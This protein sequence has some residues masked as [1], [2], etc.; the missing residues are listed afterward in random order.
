MKVAL[1]A[2]HFGVK[3]STVYRWLKSGDLNQRKG[4]TPKVILLDEK[5]QKLCAKKNR[6][7]QQE[8]EIIQQT[9]EAETAEI[10]IDA[11]A[12]E[13]IENLQKENAELGE[14]VDELRQSNEKLQKEYD[15]TESAYLFL[16]GCENLGKTEEG[17]IATLAKENEALS[18]AKANLDYENE[19]L[20][21]T[22]DDLQREKDQLGSFV[23]CLINDNKRMKLENAELR[24]K[25]AQQQEYIEE[26]NLD[27]LRAQISEL[28]DRC[29]R[30]EKR[31]RS[32][33]KLLF[34]KNEE[35][36]QLRNP[37]TTVHAI[38]EAH[39]NDVVLATEVIDEF[40]AACMRAGYSPNSQ[41]AQICKE[42][43]LEI[44]S[45][46]MAQQIEISLICAPKN[47]GGFEVYSSNGATA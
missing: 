36:E 3:L 42:R 41:F 44:D 18:K 7:Y 32:S 10:K 1:V 45:L 35:I 27:E 16:A 37:A 11:K 5:F 40:E 38:V 24:E 14:L 29:T 22:T 47:I 26:N 34:E 17:V 15:T 46:T 43:G 19:I 2:E 12:I 28:N 31:D 30:A 9:T 23:I 25:L 13:E 6:P 39:Q 8:A 33:Q 21:L 4:M 20:S